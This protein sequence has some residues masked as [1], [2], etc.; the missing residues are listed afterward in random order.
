MDDVETSIVTL[1]VGDD[2][3][4]THVATT[5]GHGDDT[6]V[7][8]DEVGDL[9]SGKVNLDSVVD[10]DGRVGVTDAKHGIPQLL[11]SSCV[12]SLS[13]KLDPTADR[14]RSR[15]YSRSCIVRNQVW[16]T[17]LSKLDTLDLSE[18]VLGLLAG[19][20]VDGEA[21]L[22]VVDETEVLAGLLNA[23]DVHE[24][25]WVGGVGA[26]LAVDL[27]QALH[28][29]GLGLTSVERI[30]EAVADEDDEGHAVAELVGTGGCPV[31]SVLVCEK[32]L[33]NVGFFVAGGRWYLLGGIGAGEFVQ[34]PVRWRRKTGLVLLRSSSHVGDCVLK[35]AIVEKVVS[36]KRGKNDT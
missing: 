26:D 1:T 20:A 32:T 2:T 11:F 7:E 9:A 23:D 8:A 36:S 28:D 25:S 18:L 5:G 24:A 16:D 19:D 34:E 27:D 35:R 17:A 15:L 30:L 12:Y 33:P 10:L 31:K 13:P 4:T 22:G 14:C 21:T 3:N 6:S 29:N